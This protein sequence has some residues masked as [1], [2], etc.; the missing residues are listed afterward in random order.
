MGPGRMSHT[1]P[2]MSH[3][4][5]PGARYNGRR[6]S[7]DPL[8]DSWDCRHIIYLFVLYLWASCL[9]ETEFYAQFMVIPLFHKLSWLVF[10]DI[11]KCA[12]PV[13]GRKG[14]FDPGDGADDHWQETLLRLCYG[15]LRSGFTR[16]WVFIDIASAI[17]SAMLYIFMIYQLRDYSKYL[18]FSESLVYRN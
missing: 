10:L 3:N 6:D 2:A 12:T 7:W 16:H 4:W 5:D 15:L 13:T 1:M 17:L 8:Q 14:W 11:S 9:W 18:I